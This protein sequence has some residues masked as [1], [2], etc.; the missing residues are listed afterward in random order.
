MEST[1]LI[2]LP[3]EGFTFS[4]H[5]T[6]EPEMDEHEGEMVVLLFVQLADLVACRSFLMPAS[7]LNM[8]RGCWH[9]PTG[10]A[11]ERI[12]IILLSRA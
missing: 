12:I 1:V 11:P 4:L 3:C 9:A 6:L 5:Q 8:A 10:K 2:D 7:H